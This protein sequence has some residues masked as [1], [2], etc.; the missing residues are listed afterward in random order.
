MVKMEGGLRLKGYIKNG[1]SENPLISVITV[2]FNGEKYL[3]KTIQSVL[4]Q[5]HGN[6]EYII[7]DGGSAD[8]TLDIIKKYEYAIDYWVSEP[9]K[10]IYDAMNKGVLLAGGEWI[11]FMNSGDVFYESGSIKALSGYFREKESLIYG[12][13]L[14]SYVNFVKKIYAKSVSSLWKGMICCH[15]SIFARKQILF[16]LGFNEEYKMAADYDFLCRV[17]LGG[18]LIRRVDFVISKV[19][20]GGVTETRRIETLRELMRISERVFKS[21]SPFIYINYQILILIQRLKEILRIRQTK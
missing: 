21:K 15:Q 2:V 16:K 20:A 18:Y 10:G 11:N 13:V 9:D 14:I 3:E 12:D 5:T 17:Y 1:S 6:I 19:I 4:G 7:I 8:K